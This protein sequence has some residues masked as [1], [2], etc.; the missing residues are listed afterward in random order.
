LL[1]F[2]KSPQLLSGQSW[3][4][5]FGETWTNITFAAGWSANTDKSA[6]AELYVTLDDGNSW[7]LVNPNAI[8]YGTPQMEIFNNLAT[9]PVN[10]VKIF[11]LQAAQG[12]SLAVEVTGT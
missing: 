4:A 2:Y 8:F 5:L 10:G 12:N 7:E 9:G 3:N 11:V 1:A 6:T